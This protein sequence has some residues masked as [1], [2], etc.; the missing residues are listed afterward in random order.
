MV[1]R[2]VDWIAYLRGGKLFVGF[3][4]EAFSWLKVRHVILKNDIRY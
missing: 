4:N 1:D 3:F 2:Q